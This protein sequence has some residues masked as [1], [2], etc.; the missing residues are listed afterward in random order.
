MKNTNENVKKVPRFGVLDLVI[1]L[2]V[3]VAVVGIYF[4]YNII[5]M[6]SS[7]RDLKQYTVSY[8][9]DN[10]RDTTANFIDVGDDVYFSADDK[11][12]GTLISASA[13]N[14]KVWETP[15]NASEVFK[16]EDGSVVEVVYPSGSSRTD[17]KGR[18]VCE[19]RYSDDGSFLVNGS[20]P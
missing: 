19:G 15:Y 7:S 14:K 4:R 17:A 20:T 6:V 9:I 12:L 10:I 8:S 1:I 3:I 18:L 5:E 11:K 13:D 2:L 16:M